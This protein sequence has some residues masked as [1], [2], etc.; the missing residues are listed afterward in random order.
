MEL[1]GAVTAYADPTNKATRNAEDLNI[2]KLDL[3]E[4]EVS[5]Q[6]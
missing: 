5:A 4:G 6:L 2:L 1:T 3:L